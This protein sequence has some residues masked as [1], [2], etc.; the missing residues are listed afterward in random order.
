VESRGPEET[1]ECG[2]DHRVVVNEEHAMGVWPGSCA[3]G[4]GLAAAARIRRRPPLRVK[5]LFR[6]FRIRDFHS[7][8]G[9][10]ALVGT[11]EYR[12]FDK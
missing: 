7:V 2:D 4:S 11:V 9:P 3:G 6:R 8:L 10:D 12:A 5:H 1:T